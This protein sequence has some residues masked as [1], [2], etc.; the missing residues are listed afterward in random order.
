MARSILAHADVYLTVSPG[1]SLRTYALETAN[2]VYAY[3]IV[4]A[5]IGLTVIDVDLARCAGIAFAA[6]ADESVV[7][8]HA[9]IR[10]DRTARVADTLIDFRL[11]LQPVITGSTFADESLQLI[12]AR[13]AVLARIGRAVIDRVL[14]LLAG[15]TRLAS[16]SIIANL[17][18]ALTVISAWSRGAL[19]DVGLASRA[20]PSRMADAFVTEELIH[21]DPVQ[22]RIA[23]AQ[24][25]LFVATFAGKSGRTIT[26]EIGDQI[27]AVGTEQAG[28]LGAIVGVDL[29]ALTFP[30]WQTIALVTPL[31]KGHTCRTVI[32]RISARCT[33]I[34]LRK[35]KIK[36]N[37]FYK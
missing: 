29:A 28:S 4:Q 32:A 9:A 21:T 31:L 23:R 20:G 36:L 26:D 2:L 24:V 19:I 3:R 12:Q 18:N 1:P 22:T 11:A 33:R 37:I 35:R 27:S 13:G 14:A 25:N 6:M 16:T 10:A 7:E 34:Y 8:I 5:R 17:V 15:I 30:S